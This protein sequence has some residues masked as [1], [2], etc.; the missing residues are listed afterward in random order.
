MEE[1]IRPNRSRSN[2]RTRNIFQEMREQAEM[3][4]AVSP[5]GSLPATGGYDSAPMP[6]S[7]FMDMSN[8]NLDFMKS[9]SGAEP[10][11]YSPTT[12][13]YSP[14]MSHHSSP[15][16]SHTPFRGDP[17]ESKPNFGVSETSIYPPLSDPTIK[18]NLL[19][20]LL[21]IRQRP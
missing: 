19:V 15:E 3:N 1:T 4:H 5:P 10:S 12:P 8:L 13:S 2:Q 21:L 9:E 11:Q 7:D 6:T 17:F 20:C 14:Q 18:V 16:M